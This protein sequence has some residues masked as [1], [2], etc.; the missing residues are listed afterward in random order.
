M[1]ADAVLF[2]PYIPA[3]NGWPI[4]YDNGRYI[5]RE[6]CSTLFSNLYTQTPETAWKK[7]RASSKYSE[8]MS[9]MATMFNIMKDLECTPALMAAESRMYQLESDCMAYW[10]VP[11]GISRLAHFLIWMRV[12]S[13]NSA[14]CESSRR[15]FTSGT[16]IESGEGVS[17]HDIGS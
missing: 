4:P 2:E 14:R 3:L 5:L 11:N 15:A 8:L 17:D 10:I 13:G 16:K 9:L 6:S 12:S 7:Y 1:A